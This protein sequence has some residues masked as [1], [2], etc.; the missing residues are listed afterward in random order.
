M[1][2]AKILCLTLAYPALADVTSENLAYVKALGNSLMGLP[3]KK[4]GSF[5]GD[6]S[7]TDEFFASKI[8]C[9]FPSGPNPFETHLSY[10]DC[11][12]K[13]M[14]A[15]EVGTKY[16][17]LNMALDKNACDGDTC[18]Q[19][20]KYDWCGLKGA[21]DQAIKEVTDANGCVE[22]TLVEGSTI[23]VYK[24][25]EDHQIT[26][27]W[28]WWKNDMWTQV[29]EKMAAMTSQATQLSVSPS[30]NA[31]VLP[32]LII[33]LIVGAVLG[34]GIGKRQGQ[35]AAGSPEPYMKLAA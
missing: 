16:N 1:I 26:M 31:M 6:F 9:K 7:N 28:D 23:S 3:P 33:G 22:G 15:S 11:V 29:D 25:N 12:G 8:S 32:T 19:T 4:G 20:W 24:L 10:E 17:M 13:E 30:S 5:G 35:S 34:Y 18:F 14:E 21:T 2:G 27:L